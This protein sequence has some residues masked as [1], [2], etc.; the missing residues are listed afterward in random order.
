MKKLLTISFFA[1]LFASPAWAAQQNISTITTKQSRSDMRSA[2]NTELGKVQSN[3]TELYSLAIAAPW[4]A[5]TTA[6]SITNVFWVDTSG[7]DPVIKYHNGTAW[8]V[9]STGSGGTYTLPAATTE[10]LG[11]VKQG[12]GTSIA[13][14]GTLS[15]TAAGL[16]LGTSDSPVFAGVD[17]GVANTTIGLLKLYGNTKAFPFQVFSLGADSPGVGWRWPATVPSI[18]SLV[19]VDSNGYWD[20]LDPATLGGGATA[21]DDLTDVDTTGKATGKI[22]KFDAS[23]NLVVGDDST[24]SGSVPSGTVNG[25]LLLWS[26]DQW[27]AS[28]VPTWNQNT[29]GT[30]ANITGIAAIANGGTGASTASNAF[31]ALKQYATTSVSGVAEFATDAET[32]TGTETTR[33]LSVSNLAAKLA[34]P[35]AL[36]GTAPGTGAFTTLVSS[37]FTSSAADGAH[38]LDVINGV[39][40]SSAATLGR[41][42]YYNGRMRL[43]DGTDWDGY[44][45]E[46]T[47]IDDTPDNGSLTTAPSSNWAYD[48]TAAT[49]PHSGYVLESA[50]GSGVGTMLASAPGSAGGPTT[51]IASGTSTLGTGAISSG[52]C[53]SA[54]TTTATGTA[55]TDVINWGFNGSPAAVTGYVAS[56]NGML[57][58]IAYPS[59]GNVNFLVCNNT[60]ASITPGAVT[61]NWRIQR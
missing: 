43:A 58:I 41:I 42:A 6:P 23:G 56:A 36:G 54:V 1:L 47:D 15:V 39:A 19:T 38:Y 3:T 12:S 2:I 59:S 52:A 30:A 4:L 60:A 57:T 51:T 10:D 45:L 61:I 13:A 25:Q 26:T 8:V 32:L 48:H 33:M 50:L 18:T 29:T 35:G 14:D 37:F 55:T 28:T 53:A 31:A 21:I 46:D 20:Y 27:V 9:A 34:S 44:F 7:T 22:L 49:D 16:G 24:G 5:Q 11:G 40:V 17:L